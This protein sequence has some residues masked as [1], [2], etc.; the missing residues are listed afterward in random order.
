MLS[1]KVYAFTLG[2]LLFEIR[3]R[4]QTSVVL[5]KSCTLNNISVHLILIQ[6]K[7]YSR[8]ND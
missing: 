1:S 5:G 3:I 6:N 8:T 4:G 7:Y 2:S